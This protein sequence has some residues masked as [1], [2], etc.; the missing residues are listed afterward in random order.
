MLK[1]LREKGQA[2]ASNAA[3]SFAKWAGILCTVLI[4]PQIW[5]AA[6]WLARVIL[7]PQFGPELAYYLTFAVFGLLAMMAVSL[8]RIAWGTSVGMLLIFMI[9]KLPII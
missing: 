2:N 4:T 9:T 5:L 8:S 3:Q 6:V 7:V 1:G